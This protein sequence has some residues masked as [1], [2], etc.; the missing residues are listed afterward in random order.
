MVASPDK[1]FKSLADLVAAAKARP[2]A[3]TFASA[4]V[5]TG[6]HLSAVRLMSSAGFEALHVPFRGGPDVL[7]EVM[8]GRVD[9]FM[10]PVG[11]ALPHISAGKLV[12]LVVNSTER[13]SVLP[14]VP[15]AAEVGLKDAEYPIWVGMFLPV[16][17]SR[18]I[19]ATLHREALKALDDP[20]VRSKLALL[21][22]D[23][24]TRTPEEFDAQVR[25]EIAANAA[26]VKAI[27]LGV[28]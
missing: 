3:M 8:S 12:A 19:V 11:V 25:E 22:V 16:K 20:K 9:F 27:G 18:D 2:G 6:T 23:P 14:D 10:A 1:G 13:S 26:L 21:G 15:T 5:G 28:Q 4:G 17:T 7:M 24:M